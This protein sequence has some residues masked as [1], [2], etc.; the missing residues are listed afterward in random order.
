MGSFTN[1]NSI[2]RVLNQSEFWL[3]GCLREVVTQGGIHCIKNYLPDISTHQHT[4]TLSLN[5]NNSKI[6][7]NT[8][9]KVQVNSKVS[10]KVLDAFCDINCPYFTPDTSSCLI[11]IKVLTWCCLWLF[12]NSANRVPRGNTLPLYIT[13]IGCLQVF[14]YWLVFLISITT[15]GKLLF[16]QFVVTKYMIMFGQWN[17]VGLLWTGGFF[18]T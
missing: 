3:G 2:D 9:D 16:W 10:L 5:Y 8:K 14:A 11:P 4:C 13:S 12:M 7:I 18:L 6:N 15:E 17:T 1:S